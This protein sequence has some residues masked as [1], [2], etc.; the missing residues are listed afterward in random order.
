M[1]YLS[2]NMKNQKSVVQSCA[3][4]VSTCMCVLWSRLY[5]KWNPPF[6]GSDW[7]KAMTVYDVHKR[8]KTDHKC[9]KLSTIMLMAASLNTLWCEFISSINIQERLNLQIEQ[10][11]YCWLFWNFLDDDKIVF[12][13]LL[14]LHY[15]FYI[16]Y[17][18][19]DYRF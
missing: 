7:R 6:Y 19:K 5:R 11:K 9:L 2:V 1:I 14:L 8:H 13:L 4:H 10:Y 12:A 18:F 15:R 16:F 3:V 17:K